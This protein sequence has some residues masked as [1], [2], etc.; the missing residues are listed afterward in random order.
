MSATATEM[1]W[2]RVLVYGLGLSGRFLER[3]RTGD[4]VGQRQDGFGG[5]VRYRGRCVRGRGRPGGEEGEVPE[6][7]QD[8]GRMGK[9]RTMVPQ[10]RVFFF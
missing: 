4:L 5:A 9:F 6:G 7:S 8:L 3:Q 2:R 10:Q 1:P